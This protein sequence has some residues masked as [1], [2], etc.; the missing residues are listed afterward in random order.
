MKKLYVLLL[1]LIGSFGLVACD[2]DTVDVV[3]TEAGDIDYLDI[4]Y[5]NDFHGAILSSDDNIGLANIA[6]LIITNKEENPD[7]V[8]VLA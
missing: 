6:N 1:L 5:L 2:N 7:N 8:I 4:Y 3:P